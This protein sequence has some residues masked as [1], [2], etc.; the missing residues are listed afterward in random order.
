MKR[1]SLPVARRYA[2]ALLDV[3]LQGASPAEA[4]SVR[5]DIRGALELLA[6]HK[7]LAGV[8]AHPAIPSEKKAQVVA[9]VW[10]EARASR[11]FGRF[12]ALLVEHGR[13][14]LLPAIEASYSAQWNERRNVALAQVVS[15]VALQPAQV[16]A[17]AGVLESVTTR[18]VEIESRLDPEM[19][20]GVLVRVGG[21][22][23]DGTVRGRLRALRERLAGGA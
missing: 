14:Q 3:A 12:M 13:V 1:V 11:V 18:G 7:S 5:R 17:I 19:L 4:E 10:T 6:E 9:A 15:A 20:G 21:R 8:L 16:A 23:Y 22:S 2:S